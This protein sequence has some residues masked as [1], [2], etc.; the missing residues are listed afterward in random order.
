MPLSAQAA[1]S[2]PCRFGSLMPEMAYTERG[3]FVASVRFSYGR[4]TRD[5]HPTTRKT[6]SLSD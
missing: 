6:E 5:V 3:L 1:A 2:I 4:K